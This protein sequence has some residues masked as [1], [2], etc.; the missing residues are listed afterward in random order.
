MSFRGSKGL[1]VWILLSSKKEFVKLKLLQSGQAQN[2][3]SV[4]VV[5]IDCHLLHS[6]VYVSIFCSGFI[7]DIV[8]FCCVAVQ[9]MIESRGDMQTPKQEQ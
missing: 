4:L 9:F 6:I 3:K 8:Y 1:A 7:V 2:T 5:C